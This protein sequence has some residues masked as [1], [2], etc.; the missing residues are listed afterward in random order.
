MVIPAPAF[1]DLVMQAA[2]ADTGRGGGAAQERFAT[3]LQLLQSDK[4][5]AQEYDSYVHQVS[6]A[7]TEESITFTAAINALNRLVTTN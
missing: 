4:L 2:A 7:S 1:K 3:M 6:F 5:W